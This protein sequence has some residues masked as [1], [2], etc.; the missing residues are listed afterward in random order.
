M[1]RVASR[2]LRNHTAGVLRRAASGE[3]IEI[4]VNGEAVAK[5][6]PLLQERTHWTTRADLVAKLSRIQADAGLADDLA[7]LGGD[8]A[9][10]GPIE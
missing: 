6:S 10:L 8:T 2:E 5:L 3:S 9:E 4:T 1:A 7:A